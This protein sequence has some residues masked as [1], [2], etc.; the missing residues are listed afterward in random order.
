MSVRLS[1][2]CVTVSSTFVYSFIACCWFV[3]AFRF[4]FLFC[5][6]VCVNAVVPP[7]KNTANQKHSIQF[8]A[9]PNAIIRMDCSD[10]GQSFNTFKALKRVDVR[11]NRERRINKK[12]KQ[13]LISNA[14]KKNDGKHLSVTRSFCALDFYLQNIIE[15]VSH[16]LPFHF[17][18]FWFVLNS[19]L[20]RV[21]S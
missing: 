16:S 14:W 15:F 10:D 6:C 12:K 8:H 17:I 13:F 2:L 7:Y 5:Q 11:I 3:F 18:S 1:Q 21:R 4:E 19:I 9:R 20:Y